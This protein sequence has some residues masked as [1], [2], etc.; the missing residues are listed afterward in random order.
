MIAAFCTNIKISYTVQWHGTQRI[1]FLNCGEAWVV[2][3]TVEFLLLYL[4]GFGRRKVVKF[5][6][7]VW[8]LQFFGA[9]EKHK[10]LELLMIILCQGNHCVV[11]WF[12]KLVN[13]LLL[14]GP[15][16]VPH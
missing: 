3:G 12:S 9:F 6:G 7:D 2:S 10:A 14:L 5:S 8:C 15:L 4:R 11:G 13:E 16:E 1:G